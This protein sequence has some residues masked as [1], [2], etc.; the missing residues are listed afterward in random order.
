Q[1]G[2]NPDYVY[3]TTEVDPKGTYRISGYRGSSRFVEIT[4]Q[5]FDMLRA[6]RK[7]MKPSPATHDFDE[8]IKVGKDGYFSVVLSPERPAGHTGDWWKLYPDTIRLLMRKCAADWNREVDARVAIDRLDV[9]GADPGS[10]MR[11]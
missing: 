10:E 1:G 7:G 9:D 8:D 2:P 3:M 6:D 4:Q 11:P 5:S